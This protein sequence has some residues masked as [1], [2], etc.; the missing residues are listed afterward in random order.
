MILLNIIDLTFFQTFVFTGD[1]LCTHI[2]HTKP[3]PNFNIMDHIF[4]V[5][6]DVKYHAQNF[7]ANGLVY[8][9]INWFEAWA[10]D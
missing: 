9:P 1:N 3:H 8:P 5:H 2:H 6:R 10:M 7:N 4:H